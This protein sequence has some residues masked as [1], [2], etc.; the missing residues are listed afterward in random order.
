MDI[1][2][3]QIRINKYLASCGFCSRRDADKLIEQGVVTVNG[4]IAVQGIKVN[5]QDE[6]CVRGKKIAGRDKKVVLAYY[7]PIGVVCTERDAH[8]EKIVTGEIRYPIRVTYAGRLDKDSEGLLLMTN[9]GGLIDAMMRGANRHEKEYIVKVTKDWTQEALEHMRRGV[10]LEELDT[11]TRPCKIEQLGAKTI[12]MVLTQGLN[13]QIRRMCRTQGY[14]VSSLK[15]TRV[16]NV[17]LEDLR[18]GEYRELT[19]N[20]MECLYRECG[21]D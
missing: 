17:E 1:N 8:A 19:Q 10:Y 3:E 21:L 7:K 16:M 12:R 13:R 2:M 5:A 4:E 14:E 20:E 11:K 6:V 18:V 9:D 15:R